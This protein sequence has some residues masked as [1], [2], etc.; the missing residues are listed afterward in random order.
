MNLKFPH[1]VREES[2]AQLSPTGGLH[3]YTLIYI[4]KTRN[5]SPFPVVISKETI[6]RKQR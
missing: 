1:P 5:L 2:K 3:L 4:A 6:E